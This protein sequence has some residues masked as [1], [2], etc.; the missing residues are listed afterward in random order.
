M[1]QRKYLLREGLLLFTQ[2]PGGSRIDPNRREEFFPNAASST[3][4][5]AHVAEK[6]NSSS[7][8]LCD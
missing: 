5:P 7:P 4:P 1:L 8:L 2:A 6:P 3:P